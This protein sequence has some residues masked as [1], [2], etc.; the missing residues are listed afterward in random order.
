MLNMTVKVGEDVFAFEGDAPFADVHSLAVE[1]FLARALAQQQE[2]DAVT[3]RLAQ[4]TD[5]L[6]A[7]VHDNANTPGA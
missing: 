3:H 1:F 6:K 2:V 5:A 4:S 7:A